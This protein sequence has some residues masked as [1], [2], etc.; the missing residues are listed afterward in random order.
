MI[1]ALSLSGILKKVYG[2]KCMQVSAAKAASNLV[3][4]PAETGMDAIVIQPR[5]ISSFTAKNFVAAI[6]DRHEKVKVI[7]I[8]SKDSDANKLDN[9]EKF[10]IRKVTQENI[11][12]AIDEVL[13]EQT[14]SEK[15][16]IVQSNDKKVLFG[17]KGKNKKGR[18]ILRLNSN[19]E[20]IEEQEEE[21]DIEESFSIPESAEIDEVNEPISLSDLEETLSN[22]T[23]EDN[24]SIPAT[25]EEE[26]T[27]RPEATVSKFANE[28]IN[29]EEKISTEIPS[30]SPIENIF[31][32]PVAKKE[33]SIEERI[34][35]ISEFSDW[36]LLKDAC[37][38]ENL[39]V[40]LMN[41]SA[42]YA[43]CVNYMSVIEQRVAT[44]F[45]D[46]NLTAEEKMFKIR[47]LGVEKSGIKAQSNNILV[48]K[49]N[50]VMD[51]I[52]N[53][54]VKEMDKRITNIKAS[55]NK[56]VVKQDFFSREEDVRKLIDQRLEIQVGIGELMQGVIQTYKVMSNNSQEIIKGMDE[57]LPTENKY[58]N[59]IMKPYENYFRPENASMLFMQLTQAV[60][61]KRLILSAI[62]DKLQSLWTAVF[63]LIELDSEII[64]NYQNKLDIFKAQNTEEVVVMTTMLKSALRVYIGPKNVGLTT[65][66]LTL[67]GC[68]ARRR[69][70]I[71]LDLREGN[72]LDQYKVN[73]TDLDTFLTTNVEQDLVI[74]SEHVTD[75]D[76]LEEILT[77]LNDKLYY[78]F[79]INILIDEEQVD[80]VERLEKDLRTIIFVTNCNRVSLEK[81]TEI[82]SKIKLNNVAQKIIEIAPPIDAAQIAIDAGID[83]TR[84]QV[85]SIPYM[86]EVARCT[87]TGEIP[88]FKREIRDV[89]E[90]GVRI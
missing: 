54:V 69:N 8:Y 84:C 15:N 12:E 3:L 41:E 11:K 17:D 19:I 82:V 38:I 5:D 76:R 60:E 35:N 75:V 9:V 72:K 23:D 31:A 80:F 13:A 59:E 62:E 43:G 30:T 64:E 68:Q 20:E 67:S 10:F 70:T 4:D 21:E 39:K 83:V 34:N 77:K 55:L 27:I 61:E 71:L 81:T 29:S 66:A 7:Y 73:F 79:N 6:R 86:V 32:P 90:A 88:Y 33:L 28:V 2:N 14:L 48:Q 53:L 56:L 37:N 18:S 89:Y 24:I 16:I 87:A 46:N 47:E 65:T 44:L 74:C 1:C 45:K 50:S 58:I 42:Q 63:K 25:E 57:N 36:G 85:T 26:F 22:T 40:E 51:A 52:T 78:Y 49:Y